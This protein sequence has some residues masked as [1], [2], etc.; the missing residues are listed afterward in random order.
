MSPQTMP[1]TD[2]SAF[3]L[4]PEKHTSAVPKRANP[5][6]MP[7]REEK[8]SWNRMRENT[9]THAGAVYNSTI[10]MA[11][12]LSWMEICSELK[13]TLMLNTPKRQK[14]SACFTGMRAPPQMPVWAK[15]QMPPSRGAPEGH[16]Q[17]R[18]AFFHADFGKRADERPQDGGGEHI[19]IARHLFRILCHKRFPPEG[20]RFR[21]GLGCVP[22]RPECYSMMKDSACEGF[23]YWPKRLTVRA[24]AS[25]SLIWRRRRTRP[26]GRSGF[27]A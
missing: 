21:A 9:A 5:R 17:R 7:L 8:L 3:R 10:A 1:S 16:L 19:Q 23:A 14:N 12:P 15:K 6:A 27:P 11:A 18:K 24:R 4:P 22:P 20:R 26:S 25:S 13:N 2:G